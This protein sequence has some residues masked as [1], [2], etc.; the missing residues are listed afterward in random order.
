M[1][2][3]SDSITVRPAEA[4]RPCRPL[5]AAEPDH[6]KSAAPRPLRSRCQSA[7][8]RPTFLDGEDHIACLVAENEAGEILGFQALE[9]HRDLPANWADIATFAR[10]KP[11]TPGVGSAL[12]NGRHWR[13]PNE[14]GLAAI[15][16]TVRAD[17]SG[18]LAY[19]AKMGFED[20]SVKR[21]VPLSDGRPVDRISK[22]FTIRLKRPAR[23]GLQRESQVL[24]QVG[25]ILQ[26]D[27]EAQQALADA[28]LGPAPPPRG[29]DGSWSPDG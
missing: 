25:R 22:K 4:Q 15:N 29:A 26:A 1:T 14:E 27:G 28:E 24:D 21:A 20:Y 3:E 7:P 17:N 11:K 12:F 16:A 23:S 13:S 19:Y 9:R 6:S 5:R 2:E 10:M 18:G 8:S